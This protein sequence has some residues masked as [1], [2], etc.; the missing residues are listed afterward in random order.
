MV[1]EKNILHYFIDTNSSRGYVSFFDSNFR[2][3]KKA[4]KLEGCPDLLTSQLITRPVPGL[5]ERAFP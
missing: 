5:W 4:V 2:G 3:V 1:L